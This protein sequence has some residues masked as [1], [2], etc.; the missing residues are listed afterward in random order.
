MGAV[1]I[2]LPIWA[3]GEYVKH[4][5]FLQGDPYNDPLTRARFVSAIYELCANPAKQDQIRAEMM[6]Y[7]R[8]RFDWER[9]I[10]QYEA[11]MTEPV[12]KATAK[13]SV[14]YLDYDPDNRNTE[15]RRQSRELLEKHLNGAELIVAVNIK[16]QA[17]ALNWGLAQATGDFLHVVSNDVMI[18]DPDWLTKLA[19]PDTITAY[20]GITFCLTGQLDLALDL[21]CIPR[22]V[23]QAI[24]GY[25]QEYADGY[26]WDDNHLLAKARA[27]GFKTE[28]RPVKA[29]HLA[30]SGTFRAYND[31]EKFREMG[32]RNKAIFKKRWPELEPPGGWLA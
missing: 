23:Y 29:R 15:M 20:A 4:G 31:L 26:G 10:D 25:E 1:P 14:I 16:G 12:I 21:W 24:G 11:W 6:P 19:A 13:H 3:V 28:I 32:E 8:E 27:A 5:I 2:C 30:A 9:M 7:A 22:N 18:E 17:N